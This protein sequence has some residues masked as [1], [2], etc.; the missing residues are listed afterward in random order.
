MSDPYRDNRSPGTRL[1]WIAIYL[2]LGLG[3]GFLIPFPISLLAFFLTIVGID[4]LRAR[5]MMKKMGIQSIREMLGRLSFH[6]GYQKVK[7]YCMSCGFEHREISCPKCGS[8]MKR[9]G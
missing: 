9:V 2:G 7:Y 4:F 5:R 1:I 8:K 6:T 3:I